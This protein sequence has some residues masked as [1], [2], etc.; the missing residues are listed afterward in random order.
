MSIF[1]NLRFDPVAQVAEK[2]RLDAST[3]FVNQ[4]EEDITLV[5]IEADTG[6]GF[7]D[8]S[9]AG[10]A[11]ASDWYLDWGYA[12][13]GDKTVSLEITTD[14]S[15]VVS[16]YTLTVVTVA[17][18]ALFSS[19]ADLQKF[20]PDIMKWLPT[21]RYTWNF[22]HRKVQEKILTEIYKNRIFADDGTK[23]EKTEVLDVSEVREWAVFQALSIIFK[24]IQNAVDDVFSQKAK[25]YGKKS[26]EFQQYS[27]N[28]LK[29]DYDKD[30]TLDSD[31]KMDF[32]SGIL[33]RR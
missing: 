23:L 28:V 5:R 13:D 24:G 14:G 6:S 21:G 31:E 9:D 10:L 8:V 29:L 15:P 7:I 11:A 25:D 1:G 12:T 27:M 3:S 32:R 30:G 19:D 16:T 18:D 17:D 33:V 2:I 20:E 26:D 22:V 4:D